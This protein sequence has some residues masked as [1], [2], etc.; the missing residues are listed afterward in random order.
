MTR[1]HIMFRE[2]RNAD[3]TKGRYYVPRRTF[4]E[5]HQ[6]EEYAASVNPSREPVVIPVGTGWRAGLPNRTE[7]VVAWSPWGLD[8]G[9]S[10][11][12]FIEGIPW[13]PYDHDCEIEYKTWLRKVDFD[14]GRAYW[15]PLDEFRLRMGHMNAPATLRAS[16][17]DTP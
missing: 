11:H 3:G 10:T 13:C 6:A 2:D 12:T 9:Y 5:A 15:M 16:G 4:D 8:K 14:I 1:Y 17:D 7:I